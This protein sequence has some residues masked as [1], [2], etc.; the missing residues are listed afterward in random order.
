MVHHKQHEQKESQEQFILLFTHIQWKYK[1]NC[2][3]VPRFPKD[4]QIKHD[5]VHMKKKCHHH[6]WTCITPFIT[7]LAASLIFS[8]LPPL[9]L[10][11]ISLLLLRNKSISTPIME[12]FRHLFLGLRWC[13]KPGDGQVTVVVHCSWS[14]Y[15][16]KWDWKES[17]STRTVKKNIWSSFHICIFLCVYFNKTDIFTFVCKYSIV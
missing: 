10:T 2:T 8:S 5:N 4:T 3:F 17:L 15:I 1:R 9:I 11:S 6:H 13:T 16:Y 14:G 12:H 7:Q